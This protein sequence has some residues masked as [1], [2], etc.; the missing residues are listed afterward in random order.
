MLDTLSPPPPTLAGAP[1]RTDLPARFADKRGHLL[2]N[3]LSAAKEG[4][5]AHLVALAD[6]VLHCL[7]RRPRASQNLRAITVNQSSDPTL[8]DDA[9]SFPW[10]AWDSLAH[11]NALLIDIDHADA[12]DRWLDLP[13]D[14]RPVLVIDP[15]T[16]R[17]HA[18][19][20]LDAPVLLRTRAE[21]DADRIGKAS[22]VKDADRAKLGPQ[23]MADLAGRLLAAALGGTLL[24]PGSLTKSPWGRT[25]N[26]TGTRR[27]IGAAAV[28]PEQWQAI[29]EQ[30]LM[31][32]T[33][34]GSGPLKLRDLVRALADTWWC[35][36]AGAA[37]RFSAKRF[38]KKRGDP[39]WESRNRWVFDLTRLW[40][41]DRAEK[42]G[43][44][45]LDEAMAHNA[46]LGNPL[47]AS[48]VRATARSITRFMNSRY[49]P[50]KVADDRRGRDRATA[51][52]L[53]PKARQAFAGKVT[54]SGRANAT[55][56]K[57][58]AAVDRL[59]ATERP[60]TQASLAAEAKVSLRTV[61]GRWHRQSMVQ[62]AALSGSAAVA[63]PRATGPV[64]KESLKDPLRSLADLAARA[65]HDRD[66]RRTV[67]TLDAAAAAARRPGADLVALPIVPASLASVP[68]VRAALRAAELAL[69]DA[70]RRA[71]VRA[72]RAAAAERAAEMRRHA[73]DPAGWTWFREMIAALDVEWNAREAAA[74]PYQL[75][76]VRSRRDAVIGGRWRTWKASRR[77]VRGLPLV[78]RTPVLEGIPW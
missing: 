59:R 45:I 50:R 74:E 1:R 63:A 61:K 3:A 75:A 23:M 34:P 41:Y 4:A 24:P 32:H 78:P 7:P 2:A 36:T 16:G 11:R 21:M 66:V 53:A 52:D 8:L 18:V 25:A 64:L 30:G 60:I 6:D 28:F 68:S 20:V 27:K 65:A 13:A 42:D 46:K 56:E 70:R 49:R 72:A 58:A 35:E 54:A 10:L 5:P 57:I 62:D 43:G 31:W 15:W 9:V 33:L 55:D 76:S 44:T 22:E 73:A 37:P 29:H 48:A 39:S 40:A 17:A 12:L 77:A 38:A 71:D 67:A 69:A 47:P 26:L 19:A 14:I 51:A